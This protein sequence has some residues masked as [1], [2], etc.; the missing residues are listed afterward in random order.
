[1][2]T[3]L[4]SKQ[5]EFVIP[6]GQ[7]GLNVDPIDLGKNYIGVVVACDNLTG[8]QASTTLNL[9]V[10][11]K[12]NDTS[13]TVY[14]IDDPKTAW[15]DVIPASGTYRVLCADALGAR[16]VQIVLDK[17]TTQE[18]VFIVYGLDGASGS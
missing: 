13:R 8:V 11:E 18:K 4:I 12:T 2:S 14:K 16:T 15:G 10:G 17:T 6:S 5:F 7:T 3:F 1:M 9:R